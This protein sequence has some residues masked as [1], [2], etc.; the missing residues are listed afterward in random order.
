MAATVSMIQTELAHREAI[1]DCLARCARGL[2][3]CDVE[4][5]RGAYWPDATD[6]HM[7]GLFVGNA[8]EF[9]DFIV[10]ILK[11]MDQTQHFLGNMLIDIHGNFADIETYY[12]SIHRVRRSD[13]AAYDVVVNCRYL[14]NMELRD[15][16]WRILR[17][18]VVP[19]WF[20]IFP[21][22]AD[23]SAGFMGVKAEPGG[24]KP[25]DRS[26]QLLAAAFPD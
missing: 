21:D 22:S 17:R 18:V 16:E 6:D 24:R 10:P 12:Q 19:D 7:E 2:D 5:L 11:K 13:D 4:L 23:W 25:N 1:R 8:Y 15:D 9:I 14:D 3:R 26:Y 20:R